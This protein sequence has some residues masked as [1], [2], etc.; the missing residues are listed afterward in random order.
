L[1]GAKKCAHC[2]AEKFGSGFLGEREGKEGLGG[3]V[4]RK[5]E[6]KFLRNEGSLPLVGRNKR[7]REDRGGR[8]GCTIQRDTS[9][10]LIGLTTQ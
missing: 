6:K 10:G 3:G 5:R 2:L 9:K 1:R 4:H 8:I 7:R